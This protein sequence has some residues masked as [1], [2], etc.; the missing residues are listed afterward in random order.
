MKHNYLK[1][2]FTL[3]GLFYISLNLYALTYYVNRVTETNYSDTSPLYYGAISDYARFVNSELVSTVNYRQSVSQIYKVAA[4]VADVEGDYRSVN[5]GNWTTL[6]TWEYYDNVLGWI[7]PTALIGYPGE[8][9]GT[10]TVLINSAHTITVNSNLDTEYIVSITVNGTL[11]LNPGSSPR[12]VSLNTPSIDI[13]GASAFLGFSH[14]QASLLLPAGAALSFQNGGDIAG[15]CTPNNEIII[16]GNQYAACKNPSAG[17]YTFGQVSAAG[18]TINAQI[19][20]PPSSP[21]TSEVCAEINFSGGYTGTGTNVT[22]D[23]V[24]RYPDNTTT[25]LIDNVSLVDQNSVTSS[26]FTPTQTGQYVLTLEVTDGN[27]TNVDNVVFDITVD[28]TPPT[29]ACQ[30]VTIQ[31]DASGS[32]SVTAA[33]VDNGSSDNCAVASLALSKTDFTCADVGPNS[34]TLTVTDVNGNTD[35]CTATVTV[36]DN[37]DPVAACQN[38]TIQLDASG[39]ASVTAAQVDNGSSD[40]CA[41]ASLA[42]S[43]TDFTCAD[44]GPNSVTL[45]VTDVNGNTDTCTATVTVE[46]NVDPVAACQNVTIQL[47]A[48]G[49]ASVTAAQVDN[50]S[51]DNCAVASL[52]LSKTD[53]T[54]ADVGPNS[55]TL[56]VTDVNG[57]TDTCTATVTVEDNVDPVAA[58]Q[59][60]TIQLDAS[61]NASVTAAQVDNG[62]SDNC[63]VASLA[64]SKT[65]FTC[66]DVGP[67]SVTL[68]V[69]DVNG[70]TDTC[71]ATVTVEDN[72]DPVA[73][74]QNVTIQLDASGNASVTAAQVDNG[75]SD[76]CA[77]ASLALS[78]TDFTCADVGPNSVTLTVTDVNGNTDTCTA[79]VTVEDNVDPV[80]ACQNV[81][82]QLDA[83]GNASVTAAQVDNGSSDN[84]A[85]A[86]LALSKTDFTCA[87]VGPNSVTLT[88][89]D[90]NGNTDTCTATVT[91][92]DNVDPVAACQNVTIQ[93]DASGN[94][95]VTAAQVDNGSSD[96]C[97]VASLALSKTDFTC[98]DV[99]PNSVTLTVTDVNG[100]TDTC[101]AT[102]TVEDNV[103]P[104]AACQNVTIQL[105]ASGNASVTAA[106]V[107]NGSSDNCAVASL[108][109]S[110]TD[111]T[112]ADVGPNSVTL[113]VTD[114]NGNTD[115]C[116]ATVTVED[117]VDPV[118]ACQNVT[119]QLDASGNASVTAAQVDN[120]SSDNC[121]VA[122]LALSK[123]D[124]TCA[125]VGPNSVTL[126]VTDVNGNTD[127]CT[128]TVTVEDNVDPVAA[129]QNVT[130]QLDASGNA[131][132]TAAQV[133][134]GSSDNCA[135]A[136]LALSKTDF[137]C[138]DVGPNSVTLTV[139]D[140]N[141]N[142]DT[143]TAT[144]TVEDNVDPVAACQN[145]TIQLD[146]SGNASV[147]AAQ[148]DNGSSDNCAVASLA[149][150]KTDFTCADVGPNSVTLTV[151]DVNGNTDTCTATVT[152]EDNVDPVAACQN[153]TIQLDASGNASVTAAQVDN[154]SSDNCAVA[155][156]ALSK[157]D[158]T[159]ADVGPNSVTLTVTDVNGN[160]DTCTATV[161]V[162]DNVDPVA[163]CQ[164][165]TIQLD[166]S[167]NASVTAA[168]VDNGSSDNCA[169]ASLALSKTDF[170][171]A[172]VGPNSV[173]LTVTDVNGNTDT[174]TAT[175]TVEDNVD[176]VAACQNV[177][178]Q[179]DASGNASV[180]AAQV[181]NGSSDN[182][183]VASLALSKTDFTCADVGPNSV[184]LTVTDVNGN[185]DTCTATV[186][187]ED[188]VDPVAACQNVTIQLDASGNASVTAAQVDNG[189]SDNCAVASL[190]LSKT[191]FTC[192]DVGPNS[193]TLTVTDVNGNTDTCTATVTVE[194]NVDPVAAC[195]NVTI[196]LDA[197]GN[198]SVT[199]AQVDNGSSDNCAVASL[200][201]SKT[202]FT[203]ADVGPN[204]VTLTVTDVNGNTD[205][206]T[207]TVTVEDNVDPVAACQN[208][209][210]QLD[211]SGNASVTAAQVDNGSSDN[212]AVA[213]LALSKTDFTCADV[214]PNSVTLTV[215][216]VNGNTDT[217]TATV[218]VEDN[219]DPVAACQNVTIQL[220]ASGNASVTA[221]QVDNGSSDNCAVASLALS[222]T[223]FTCADV[224]PNSVTLTV[225]DVNGNTDTCTATV[226]V[227]DN[228][229]PVAACQ[230]VT[231]QLDASGNASVTAAQVDNGSSDNCAV[232]SLALS[233]TDFTCADVGPNS[234]TLTVTD[235]NGNTDTCTATVT[236]ED[237]V[238]PVAACQ[239]VTIQLDASGNASVTA[240]QVDNGSSDN[241]AVA[242]LALSKTDFTCAD[243]GPNS[244]TLTV[245]DVNGNTDTCTAT[246]TVE[247]NV[248]PVAAC[249]NVT[250][251]LDASG[252]ASVTAAQVDNGSSD[253][254]AVA[255]LA[256]SKTDFTCADVGPNSVTLT[257]TDVNGNTDTCTATVT[258]EDNVDPVAACQNVTIQ[259]DASGNAS[260]TAAQVDNG[261]SDNCA[262]ASLALSKTDFTCA[263][264]GPNSVTLT[265]TDVNGNTDTCTATV[266]VEDN[267]D[268][269]AACQNVTIQLDASGNASVTAAQ[270]DN[271]S[272]DNCAVASLALSKTDFTCADVG[273][274]SVTLTVTDVN[275]NTDTCTATVTVVDNIKPFITCP[276][277][278]TA[279]TSNDGTGNCTTTVNLGTP[280][281]TDNCTASGDIVFTAKI[282]T[283]TI[284]PITHLFPIGN[285]IVKWTATDEN[286]NT[287]SVCNQTVTVI[288]NESPTISC[289]G[290][291]TA[292]TSDDGTGD[293]STLINIP[294]P[295]N[296]D[297]CSKTLTWSMTGMVN[298]NGT[299]GVGNYSFPVGTTTIN[300][301]VTDG[302]GLTATCSQEVTVVD[303]ENPTITCP[304]D[305]NVNFN[306]TCEFELQ[307][308]T[309]LAISVS[310]NC[311]DDVEI[312]QSPAAGTFI[313]GTT[314]ITLTASD[315]TNT[316]S[317]S[318]N[319]IP[320]DNIDPV[321]IC[322][323]FDAYLSVNGTVTVFA[324]DLNNGS[325]DANSCGIVSMTVSPNTFNCSDIGNN[326]VTFT[327]YDDA[328]NSD[329][330]T[331]TVNVID[332]IAPTMQCNDFVT[333]VD[334]ITREA[335]IQASDVDNGSF[336]ACGSVTLSVSPTTFPEDENGN[337]YYTTAELTATDENGNSNTCTVNITV[338]P[339]K[340]EFTYL[341]GEIVNPIPDN[342][343]P[344]SS[345]IE[346]TACPGGLNEP[347]DVELT[348]Q[349]IG[350]YGLLAEHVINWE[351]SDDNGET[352]TV[353]PNTSGILTYTLIGVTSDTFVRLR[354]QNADDT[355]VIR[356]SAEAFIRFLPPDEPP[357]ITNITP[358]PPYICLNESVTLEAQSYFDRPNGQFG[359]G[360]EFNYAQPDGWR[361]DGL[362]GFFPA[363]GNTTTQPTWKETNS[364]NNQTFSG[365]NYD[366]TDNT[367]F[368]MANGVGNTTTLET[369]VFSTVG[370]TSAEA[371]MNFNTSFYFC[372]NGYGKIELS[373]DSGNTYTETLTTVEGYDF[374]SRTGGVTTSGV[375]LTTGPGQNCIGQTD[376][377]MLPATINLGAYTGLSGLRVKF[378]FVGST[379]D[380][381]DASA[382]MFSNP[383]NI[384]CK[385]SEKVA[386]GW[387]IDA[388]GFAYA[389]VDDELEWTD[390][391]GTVIAIGTTATITPVTPGI[392]T[393][394]VTNLVNQCRTDN[395]DGT[396]FVDIYTSLAYAGQDYTPLTSECGE[397]SL[398]LNAYDNTKT[399][400]ENFNKGAFE[401][402]LYVV[403]DI[404]AGDTDYLGTGVTGVWTAVANS[405]TSCGNAFTFSDNTSPDAIFTADPG[406]YTLTWT[407]S[408][409]CS[410]KINVTI[411]DCPTVNFDGVNDY[412]TFKNNYNINSAFSLEV[413]VK[414]NSVN[415]TRTVYSRKDAANNTNGYALNIVDG[416][417]R[418]NWYNTLS[419][420]VISSGG[421]LVATDRWYHL[422]VT[423]DGSL[424]TLY[425]DG[426]ELN[427]ANGSA[428]EYT[429][430]NIEAILGAMDQSPPSN[431][432]N[433]FHG[434]MDE[435]RIWNVGLSPEHIRQ[436]MNQEIIQSG[437]DVSGVV[438]PLKIYGPDTNNDGIEENPILWSNLDAYYKMGVVCGDLYP[439]VG[440]AGRLRNI[441]TSQQQT[442]PIPYTTKANTNWDTDNTWTYSDVWDVPNSNGING[443]P[444]DWNIARLSHNLTID[445]RNINL[446]GLIVNSSKTLIVTGTGTQ[447]ENNIGHGLFIS[448]YLKLDGFM[449]LIGKS[450]LIQRRYGDYV[451]TGTWKTF[452][453]RQFNE[454]ILDPNSI[455]YI[456][457]DQQGSSNVHNYNYWSSPVG[458]QNGTTNN[459]PFQP[460]TNMLDGSITSNP[461]PIT[462]VGGYD[463]SG[464]N[465]IKIAE[466]WLWSY[467]NKPA[468][469]YSNWEKLYK[470]SNLQTGL[471]YTMKGSGSSSDR[472]NYTFRG[473][474]NN[475]TVENIVNI[476]NNALVG[477][478]YPS[479]VYA[480][481]FI[482]DNIPSLDPTGDP[483]VANSG[484][485]GSIDGT[486]SFWITF[487]TNNT[488]ILREYQGGYATFTLAGGLAPP[489]GNKY[490]TTDGYEI[491][492]D[493]TTTLLPI[494]HIPV[495]QGFYVNAAFPDDF[496]SNVIRFK[497]S[498]R[499]RREFAATD[500]GNLVLKT[501]SAKDSKTNNL[502]TDEYE[503]GVQ[504]IRFAF[505]NNKGQRSL[506]LAFTPDN[507]ASDG[508][509]YGYDARLDTPLADDMLFKS[510]IYNLTI[511]AVGEFDDSKQYPFSIFTNKGG[512]FEIAVTAFENLPP[513]TKV[514]IYDSLLGTYTKIDGKNLTYNITLDPGTYKDR[515]YVTFTH[516]DQKTLSVIDEELNKIQV[517]YLQ[518]S[519][520][521][522]INSV[523]NTEI[524]QVQLINIL[525]QI[526]N[527]WDKSDKT[528]DS[529]EI[530][531]SVSGDIA[532]GSY[533]V[534]IVTSNSNISKKIIIK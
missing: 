321:A 313:S 435:F 526:I 22:A 447:D 262:V 131:S 448:H 425:V 337:V 503:D 113:T 391:D 182:C 450:Q 427:S 115:T 167:G 13:N 74:C 174:C 90:V 529:N 217:C 41:V 466:Y 513:N 353:I 269:V 106:Q 70:N 305:Q 184:T 96:N 234:V 246:V 244:V 384:N 104:V 155:S 304:G 436:M 114:V 393:Y 300:Y 46:D 333:V 527:V 168:Q 286:G 50:G 223:D 497:N 191:D 14:A 220:D 159:C 284:N 496:E 120:G 219:V 282:G 421:D 54:C 498:Q 178:I 145:V 389:Q 82:I 434:W 129:C 203:C 207:A 483:S 7:T 301:T 298:T 20:I 147:T 248:D 424:Y 370:M 99:G 508:Y 30:N 285:T 455:G 534:N 255:S 86:S 225:T 71:T 160:T 187:V 358:N 198:A 361:V 364:N 489:I 481:E 396:E 250:I 98:A 394:G 216:D 161:T 490:T 458:S 88:V 343:Q 510:G 226:T 17:A 289:S 329:S 173:T 142:T 68:T 23:W 222:K 463:G 239:N 506:L 243:V 59:N 365:I 163:A 385:K 202:D 499:D 5:S 64:L 323:S 525:G 266:T 462:W 274:N 236:V 261:S 432:T 461:K 465:P 97:A 10:N 480:P 144:V 467:R 227:E 2:L 514:Y 85:V 128:A 342:P 288:D 15:S 440:A 492:G 381:G 112:C 392:R 469:T 1:H 218:T 355:S 33:Q 127:T 349:P 102:V 519:K 232:A 186:T 83:S 283:T 49:N 374:D 502:E 528:F 87:D 149:L 340:N 347:K 326:S 430:S 210:I 474:P 151:T 476:G 3:I 401:T 166:A 123:T 418:F 105:D 43:K 477:N 412:V 199:A 205:T 501:S 180:T 204:S 523:M 77:V 330:C 80:A 493:G 309:G 171:C 494:A 522:Y 382:S 439:E 281:A 357:T 405:N 319:V 356:T 404:A 451:N 516:K 75:S 194:D 479:A 108:A 443:E 153:V 366:T 238:D 348:L 235:V 34:V 21:N 170:T 292:A 242:S 233:K 472:Q 241:C 195:Q 530:R 252:N 419:S 331:T 488:H 279:N 8:F 158:F 16:N 308:Y 197:S 177:T 515:F 437:S 511:Q 121:A 179:L 507:S 277:T 206:C 471:G 263:D 316:S 456:E 139:T 354:I 270:V 175:V 325:Y 524:K 47:D 363:S 352:W 57:N 52:A 25:I 253:N 327:V 453:T 414:P 58:C 415:G 350:D 332:N 188:N 53:F 11:D 141:G 379:S 31:L 422:A 65:D 431:P 376:P 273:P 264:V 215:T 428:P 368:A 79:T 224:G 42:L 328:G 517:N 156:L 237:N 444:I 470:S 341:T 339:P 417:V 360:G 518:N 133:D 130:I 302:A 446:L 101:T 509:N 344:P 172:D 73:A 78:K 60:V 452:E 295:T 201:L 410:D 409:G 318:F 157:T 449:D 185:T 228:V 240:A 375:F 48:S 103:D 247:D 169:V 265:V 19:D 209:T 44:V 533:I 116:T 459:M 146:A 495:A 322:E 324:D 399:S 438:I 299:G 345:L 95:S 256:L 307:D 315:G 314:L 109:L 18:G 478:P 420:G 334:A 445:A 251:Q 521:I 297:N 140:V 9:T 132:V 189:S 429:T 231:I 457:R 372:N 230:N 398:Q 76:N 387:A 426:I 136:S 267:V 94:A 532:Q 258:V 408:N 213:S 336:D 107:D 38:V 62:S 390:E 24:L 310:D 402:N 500:T 37:V 296:F 433:Y 484:T 367:K 505:K 192:A 259:L 290:N 257:V 45:T 152:V 291:I 56:T 27:V 400:V 110:K 254:C 93:L 137:T 317:C 311:D 491:S 275:G 92:E 423:F 413:W 378:T 148:V 287:S 122:S 26:S 124:F 135:V 221:A 260:V 373:F 351:Y 28:V 485:T 377:R 63:A 32:A 51:S 181:D 190:A 280:T 520:E 271:G 278:V 164:N 29:A 411:V 117:N 134:N 320:T 196:Q 200:A 119:I 214:G 312:T 464:T 212:C 12:E 294:T 55:V 276:G 61:G 40:N 69:T 208:V 395:D 268:P 4:A 150:S 143:C 362:D 442:A 91:V 346:A 272:S 454:S 245:T 66:A 416:Q 6:S 335:T 460:M 229:D 154:G 306:N 468:N 504:R 388:V 126:T 371:I 482:K 193:V 89:T 249:Q 487:D 183:A 293:C 303:D 512:N 475:E 138:A 406:N 165:V 383:D 403:P 39:N 441:T 531:L 397:N 380:C 176:P 486:L 84:C 338:E 111:F 407:L 162:E 35:T 72:V 359:E 67:N 369:P 211:A 473:K 125:D 36:E 118:A 386:S 81:T 100:N